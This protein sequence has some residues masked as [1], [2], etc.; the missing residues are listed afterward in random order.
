M[1]IDFEEGDD[2]SGVVEEGSEGGVQMSGLEEVKTPAPK[3]V[4]KDR[5]VVGKRAKVAEEEV[6][7]AV[8]KER[9]SITKQLRLKKHGSGAKKEEDSVPNSHGASN[10]D[11]GLMPTILFSTMQSFNTPGGSSNSG[12]S[13]QQPP[14]VGLSAC[15]KL[16]PGLAAK[17]AFEHK[18]RRFTKDL[19]PDSQNQAANLDDPRKECEHCGR[20]FNPEIFERHQNVCEKVF[21][22]RRKPFNSLR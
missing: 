14:K 3:V 10:L 2:A 6:K 19:N 18:R 22:K 20:R 12:Q 16:G 7:V 9:M 17:K 15:Q 4:I 11:S 5:P 21:F 1:L 8:V 13:H